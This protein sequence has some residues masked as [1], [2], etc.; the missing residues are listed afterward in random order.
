MIKL[1]ILFIFFYVSN[2]T[3]GIIN[4]PSDISESYSKAEVIDFG[5]NSSI[6]QDFVKDAR[7][8]QKEHL[9]RASKRSK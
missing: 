9:V 7:R 8:C 5:T 6:D 1:I 4:R 3:S 2:I